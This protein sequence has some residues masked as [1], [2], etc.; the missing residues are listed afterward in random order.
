MSTLG[1]WTPDSTHQMVPT[2]KALS[3]GAPGSARESCWG[4][5]LCGRQIGTKFPTLLANWDQVYPVMFCSW[6][7][8][9]LGKEV[10]GCG[11]GRALLE[12]WVDRV[13]C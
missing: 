13:H 7:I 6:E 12:Q 9:R 1:A 10:A 2:G 5:A 3:K 8:G 11:S 4:C